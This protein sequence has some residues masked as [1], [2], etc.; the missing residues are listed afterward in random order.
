MRC[1]QTGASPRFS[2]ASSKGCSM[3]DLAIAHRAEGIEEE[4]PC[5]FSHLV[6]AIDELR[7]T[8]SQFVVDVAFVADEVRRQQRQKRDQNATKARARKNAPIGSG[9][10]ED[11]SEVVAPTARRF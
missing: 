9:G 4:K 1:R 8:H 10:K 2:T 3:R 5:A 7:R 6:A 11:Q